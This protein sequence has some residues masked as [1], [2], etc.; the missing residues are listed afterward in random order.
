MPGQ[1]YPQCVVAKG[2][3]TADLPT[4]WDTQQQRVFLPCGKVP[5]VAGALLMAVEEET[6]LGWYLLRDF[7]LEPALPLEARGYQA[8]YL[9]R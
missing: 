9:R 1:G 3:H 6:P 4:P 2:R 5:T 8:E 7:A